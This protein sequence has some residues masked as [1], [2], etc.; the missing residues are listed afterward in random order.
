MTCTQITELESEVRTFNKDIL[1]KE[2]FIFQ[3]NELS[4]TIN[5]VEVNNKSM[6]SKMI[7][8]YDD[9]HRKYVDIKTEYNK[10]TSV[11]ECIENELQISYLTQRE[12]ERTL[13]KQDEES[14]NLKRE[15]MCIQHKLDEAKRLKDD[16]NYK[17][18]SQNLKYWRKIAE[19]DHIKQQ[20][21][22]QCEEI[23]EKSYQVCET[24]SRI[25]LVSENLLRLEQQV[26]VN[27][28]YKT[29]EIET[30]KERNSLMLL[31]IMDLQRL[32]LDNK[33]QIETCM[34]KLGKSNAN[35]ELLKNTM[36]HETTNDSKLIEMN[37]TFVNEANANKKEMHEIYVCQ[38]D[39]LN[40]QNS[41]AET[42]KGKLKKFSCEQQC[43]VKDL[44][45]ENEKRFNELEKVLQDGQILET[46]LNLKNNECNGIL[47]NGNN[48][49]VEKPT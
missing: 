31:R 7:K 38:N 9:L 48:P 3:L 28:L 21:N 13:G 35:I 49:S 33:I 41:K 22:S 6:F 47:N 8:D 19:C 36:K 43:R 42:L 24:K 25:K 39:E 4:A 27:K 44:N 46:A 26:T 23:S 32:L 18:F 45:V 10:H 14:E 1:V 34:K 15:L 37:Q 30:L 40:E 2:I 5:A 20:S 16:L 12:L 17:N 29:S 11:I